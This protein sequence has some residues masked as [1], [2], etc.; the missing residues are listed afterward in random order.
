MIS[1]PEH[2]ALSHVTVPHRGTGAAFVHTF[3]H[4]R[5]DVLDY[6]LNHAANMPAD[7][8]LCSVIQSPVDF[9]RRPENR[10]YVITPSGW[11]V[12]FDCVPEEKWNQSRDR[13]NLRGNQVFVSKFHR[14]SLHSRV[15]QRSALYADHGHH[16]SSMS[17]EMLGMLYSGLFEEPLVPVPETDCVHMLNTTRH[18]MLL[19]LVLPKVV[20][21]DDAKD[22]ARKQIQQQVDQEIALGEETD[23]IVVVTGDMRPTINSEQTPEVRAHWDRA[24]GEHTC[25]S[26]GM[27]LLANWAHHANMVMP[28]KWVAL[29]GLAQ[30]HGEDVVARA[31]LHQ[32][33]NVCNPSCKRETHNIGL[34]DETLLKSTLEKMNQE[35]QRVLSATL[36]EGV[37]LKDRLTARRAQAQR[38]DFHWIP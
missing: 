32:W 38:T 22:A 29:V 17:T 14:S 12:P 33:G 10:L 3:G 35:L 7:R 27:W 23:N 9:F 5:E 19:D 1:K 37:A 30:E 25:I 18:D 28:E 24:R 6:L 20:L 8:A 11:C 34:P 13:Q 15:S 2:T 31:L 26:S 4:T 36:D 21:C 16:L